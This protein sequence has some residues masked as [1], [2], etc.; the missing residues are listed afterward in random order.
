M[1][2]VD[3]RR[4]GDV[5]TEI[6]SKVLPA[7]PY[8][9]LPEPV[10]LRAIVGASVILLA[11]SIGS[12]EFVLWPYISS[13]VGL[14]AMWAAMIGITTQ[15]F[16]NMEIERYTLATGETAVTGFTRLWRGWAPLFIL[17]TI[18]PWAWPGWATGASTTLTFVFGGGDVVLITVLGLIAIG[19][20]L[21]VSPVVYKSVEKFQ[22]V[23]VGIIVLFMIAAVALATGGSDWSDFAT[24]FSNF[25]SIPSEL[26]SALLLGALAFA[27]AGGSVNLAQSN[28]I[29]DKGM[30]MG[31]NMP[32]VVS[33]FTGEEEA[34]A[35][36]GYFFPM[37]DENLRRW[38]GWWKVSNQE[39]FWTFLIIGGI[40]III[41]S[42]LTYATVFGR[43]GLANDFSFIEIEGNVLKDLVAPW[44]GN[45]FWIT[46]TVVLLSTNL[47]V[48]DH[49]GR[50]VADVVKV[51][52]LRDSEFWTESKLY[53]AIVWAEIA[54]GCGILLAGVDQPLVLLVIASSLNGLVMF[55]YSV[56]LIQLNRGVLPKQIA[57]RGIRLIALGWSVLFFGYFSVIV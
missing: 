2:V 40:S 49:V 51:N 25:G 48:L 11:T 39:Q 20:A 37:T 7:V 21:T 57:M 41:L 35:T 31:A 23:M 28:W 32:K 45:F 46:G 53:F 29:R 18:L 43:E 34:R 10:P 8:R 56:L 54:F 52:W 9:D 15:F 19:I 3:E 44:F 14:V 24:G 1:A 17:M 22:M 42:V 13:Q 12:G 6:P 30:G 5:A 26:D 38:K 33:P 27:G 36:T 55:V 16:I 47:G 4:P 50:V